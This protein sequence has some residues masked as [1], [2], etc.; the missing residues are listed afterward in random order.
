MKIKFIQVSAISNQYAIPHPDPAVP[1]RSVKLVNCTRTLKIILLLLAVRLLAIGRV[2]DPVLALPLG[3]L[4]HVDDKDGD[5]DD[6][7]KAEDDDD[8]DDE[9]QPGRAVVDGRQ[10]DDLVDPGLDLER[11]GKLDL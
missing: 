10:K 5:Q 3:P 1:S 11:E 2:L 4:P 6:E 8:K 7:E 9:P